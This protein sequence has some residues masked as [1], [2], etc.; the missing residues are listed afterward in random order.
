MSFK[1]SNPFS[2]F[3]RMSGF[4]TLFY[5]PRRDLNPG[6]IRVGRACGPAG[7]YVLF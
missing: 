3:N 4:E 6:A 2:E 5:S 7:Q 1:V